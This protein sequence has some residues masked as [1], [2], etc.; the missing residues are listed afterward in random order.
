MR[1]GRS[2]RRAARNRMKRIVVAAPERGLGRNILSE[3]I[4]MAFE[5]FP[6][7]PALLD[8]YEDN[9]RARHLYESLGFIVRRH[10]ARCGPAR[11]N[12]L[13]TCASCQCW[14]RNT[15]K[16]GTGP[17]PRIG[18]KGLDGNSASMRPLFCA[19]L[20]SIFTSR[21]YTLT[22]DGTTGCGTAIV[23]AF[24]GGTGHRRAGSAGVGALA[25]RRG[26]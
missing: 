8:V 22:S 25:D 23:S 20:N 19:P 12:V 26:H 21:G 14:K 1:A 24:P 11:G 9:D 3:I 18:H 17:R 7:T 4:R 13:Q 15:R 6:C 5:E 10:D 2:R 16:Q